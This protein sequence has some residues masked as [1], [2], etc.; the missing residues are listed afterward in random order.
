MDN[1]L[2]RQLLLDNEDVLEE[3][4]DT[5]FDV[6]MVELSDHC[7]LVFQ[8]PLVLVD[9]CIPFVDHVSDIVKHRA[10]CAHI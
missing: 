6:K 4:N 5:L 9:E 7:L 1:P 2:V 10:V 8:V 3:I